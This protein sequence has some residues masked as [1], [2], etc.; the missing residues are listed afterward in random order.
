MRL[1]TIYE[2]NVKWGAKKRSKSIFGNYSKVK[3]PSKSDF[4]DLR[5]FRRGNE[6]S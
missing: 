6:G 4:S 3:K 2:D 5:G 1:D